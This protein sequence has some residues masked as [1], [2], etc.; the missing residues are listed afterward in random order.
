MTFPTSEDLQR[1]LARY[2]DVVANQNVANLSELDD[3]YRTQL[4]SQIRARQ[5]AHVTV[6]ELARLTEWK[7]ARGVW[8]GRNLALVKS[9]DAADVIEASTNAFAE[10]PHATRPV[11]VLAKLKGVGPATASAAV[12]AARPEVYPFFD[13][14]VA[15][16]L[17]E[18]GPVKWTLSYYSRYAEAL[19]AAA[20]E[21]GGEWTPVRLEQALW[22]HVGGKAGHHP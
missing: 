18:L 8:R 10:M 9:N 17:P 2:R 14:L 22:A 20:G 12:A 15:A 19:R 7:M 3:W 5:P 4:P 16:Q 13:E 11:A 6:D 1:A 21:L